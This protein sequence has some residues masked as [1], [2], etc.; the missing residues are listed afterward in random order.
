MLNLA[1]SKQLTMPKLFWLFSLSLVAIGCGERKSRSSESASS[2]NDDIMVVTGVLSLETELSGHQVSLFKITEGKETELLLGPLMSETDGTYIFNVPL[3]G[4]VAIQEGE[5]LITM[6]G[7]KDGAKTNMLWSYLKANGVAETSNLNVLASIAYEIGVWEDD[8]KSVFTANDRTADA[9]GL[10]GDTRRLELLD[11]KN[12]LVQRLGKIVSLVAKE[13]AAST[14]QVHKSIANDI[15]DGT[16]DGIAAGTNVSLIN[17]GLYASVLVELKAV[18][19]GSEPNLDAI[20][21]NIPV[22]SP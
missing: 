22:P 3:T 17:I 18:I 10:T 19:A 9:F 11:P 6:S 1:N 4:S 15:L 20:R 21:A 13:S 2:T 7:A 14:G 5:V 16:L 8:L 12:E